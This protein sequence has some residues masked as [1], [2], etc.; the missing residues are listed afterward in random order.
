MQVVKEF[1]GTHKLH[2][3]LNE[4]CMH[5]PWHGSEKLQNENL[6]IQHSEKNHLQFLR[7]SRIR[8]SDGEIMDSYLFNH[9]YIRKSHG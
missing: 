1:K 2:A 3:I 9:Y 6:L 8:K 7:I 5:F 4:L